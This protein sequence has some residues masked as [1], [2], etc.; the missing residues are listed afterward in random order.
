MSSDDC[1]GEECV[2]CWRLAGGY[3]MTPVKKIF[4]IHRFPEI[5]YKDIPRISHHR[6]MLV[7]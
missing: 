7:C 3:A 2:A 6:D 5:L 1:C 4:R